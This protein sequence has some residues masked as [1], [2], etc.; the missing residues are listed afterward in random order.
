MFVIMLIV[1]DCVDDC[2]CGLCGGVDDYLIKLFLF[3]ELIEWLCVLMCCV[4]V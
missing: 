2:V 3:F 1:C 4:C